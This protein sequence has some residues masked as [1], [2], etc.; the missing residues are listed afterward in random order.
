MAWRCPHWR[1]RTGSR[2]VGT[3]PY[4]TTTCLVVWA[5]SLACTGTRI[6]IVLR[7]V[8]CSVEDT[9]V[10]PRNC[11]GALWSAWSPARILATRAALW[12]P[13]TADVPSVVD[14]VGLRRAGEGYVPRYT[15][16]LPDQD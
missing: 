10:G 12:S 14:A 16:S 2:A 3:K 5:A 8:G 15:L 4:R 11:V 7:E 1:L 6:S 9:G 13:G